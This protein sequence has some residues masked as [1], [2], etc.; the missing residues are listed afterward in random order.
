MEACDVNVEKI[1]EAENT[2]IEASEAGWVMVDDP[3]YLAA[4]LMF[5]LVDVDAQGF[6][7]EIFS[8]DKKPG[9][10]F[11]PVAEK[12]D[13][14]LKIDNP[15]RL[16]KIAEMTEYY[17]AACVAADAT[18]KV[19]VKD[20]KQRALGRGRKLDENELLLV[21]AAATLDIPGH[22]DEDGEDEEQTDD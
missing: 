2:G 7:H 19:A 5:G 10:K 16:S 21:G 11:C 14:Y 13:P 17:A 20:A 3:A 9:T 18:E 4:F 8:F 15:D 12:K 1:L 6:E 22:F